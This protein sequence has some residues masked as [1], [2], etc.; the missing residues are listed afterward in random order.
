MLI[1]KKKTIKTKGSTILKYLNLNKNSKIKEIYFSEIK[2]GFIKGWNLHKKTDCNISV[3]Y[4]K[5]KFTI[6]KKNKKL[7]TAIIT[8][9]K[10]SNLKIPKNHWFKY[11]SL[12]DPYSIVVNYISVNHS[13]KE[14]IKRDA[15]KFITP[16]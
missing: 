11:E 1:S 12:N 15:L 2:K 6:Y 10:F 4:G 5:V 8:R 9:K 7:K 3:I 16:E 13:D 14:I